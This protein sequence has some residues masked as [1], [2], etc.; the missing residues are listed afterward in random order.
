MIDI[1]HSLVCGTQ[2]KILD[3]RKSL[4]ADTRSLLV[5]VQ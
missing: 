2:K 5:I 4:D 1:T 3:R